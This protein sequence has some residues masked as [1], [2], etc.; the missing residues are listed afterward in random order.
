MAGAVAADALWSFADQG[1]PCFPLGRRK[2]CE[3]LG[4]LWKCSITA[5]FPLHQPH[6]ETLGLCTTKV[7]LYRSGWLLLGG[8]WNCSALVEQITEP[9]QAGG[10]GGRF[11]SL[12]ENG[13]EN[14]W[15][16]KTMRGE[17]PTVGKARH[18][19]PPVSPY[20]LWHPWWH[21]VQRGTASHGASPPRPRPGPVL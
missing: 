3:H 9:G 5:A 19:C 7:S 15:G 4:S 14:S 12:E 20:A 21:P 6:G 1:H 18:S 2:Q 11:L 16:R 10:A 8:R 17:H 13:M